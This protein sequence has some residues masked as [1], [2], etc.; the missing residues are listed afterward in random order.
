MLP[1]FEVIHVNWNRRRSTAFEA[2]LATSVCVAS[3]LP[4]QARLTG[5]GGQSAT[6]W[7]G[8]SRRRGQMT[9][10]VHRLGAAMSG[11]ELCGDEVPAVEALA[12]HR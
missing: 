8:K 11:S 7:I 5:Q 6:L 4:W 10:L 9:L 12:V 3:S 1:G 2:E